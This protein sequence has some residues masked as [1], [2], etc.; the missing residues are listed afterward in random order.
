MGRVSGLGLACVFVGLGLGMAG[1]AR[2]EPSRVAI[3][4]GPVLTFDDGSL[5]DESQ[6]GP[7]RENAETEV[8]NRR[9]AGV[10]LY[11]LYHVPTGE[12]G[13]VDGL[14]IG[15]EFRYL[16]TT[17]DVSG[18]NDED[19]YE[20]GTWME[21]GARGEWGFG[22]TADFAITA[23]ARIDVAMLLPTGDFAED[24]RRLE[25]DGVPTSDGPRVGVSLVGLVGARWM[26]LEHV[27]AH[28]EAGLGWSYMSLIAVDDAV[29]GVAYQRTLTRS[30]TRFEVSL[31]VELAF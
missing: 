12:A 30:A 2:A 7:L 14:R 1:V 24:L 15:G 4:L 3:G 22:L 11:A 28:V 31:G 27:G 23:G 6:I 9:I 26:F 18:K 29:Q 17:A 20:L 10:V 19:R 21:F 13:A 8:T 16:G 25:G 5:F